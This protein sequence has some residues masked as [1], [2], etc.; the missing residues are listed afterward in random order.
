MRV[1]AGR[2][3]LSLTDEELGADVGVVV[4]HVVADA[5][6]VA[7]QAC[8]AVRSLSARGARGAAWYMVALVRGWISPC[9]VGGFIC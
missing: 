6:Q 1:G 4:Q 7:L 8:A 9:L 5:A 3:A 2:G